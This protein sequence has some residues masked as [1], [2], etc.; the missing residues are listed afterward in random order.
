MV[1]RFMRTV[2]YNA[3]KAKFIAPV[4]DDAFIFLDRMQL[5]ACFPSLKPLTASIKEIF[6][7]PILFCR[8]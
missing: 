2:E 4:E 7:G 6:C 3:R 8:S 1:S 5:A